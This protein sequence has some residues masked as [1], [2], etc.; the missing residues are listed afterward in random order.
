MRAR[1]CSGP[2]DLM[3]L[4]APSGA[5]RPCLLLPASC[6]LSVLQSR[7]QRVVV[8]RSRDPLDHPLHRGLRRHLL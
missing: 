4:L 2:Q 8:L 5:Y 6:L 7:Q 3:Q 1:A